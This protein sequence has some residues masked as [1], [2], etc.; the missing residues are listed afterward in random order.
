MS[1][2]TKAT[3]NTTC[4]KPVWCMYFDF[5]GRVLHLKSFL[6]SNTNLTKLVACFFSAAEAWKSSKKLGNLES[7]MGD[8]QNS[9]VMS[10]GVFILQTLPDVSQKISTI[11]NGP[12]KKTISWH[13]YTFLRIQEGHVG[14]VL[15]GY[16][17]DGGGY[18]SDS[19]TTFTVEM[20]FPNKTRYQ[21]KTVAGY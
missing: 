9:T 1:H 6:E 12:S 10:Q 17:A 4:S 2:F 11:Q 3:D 8:V 18:I 16:P 20:F 21:V 7:L 14:S 15:E 19:S 13:K 5:G